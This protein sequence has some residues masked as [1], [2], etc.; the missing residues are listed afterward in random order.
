MFSIMRLDG[1]GMEKFKKIY[2]RAIRLKGGQ[3]AIDE[4]LPAPKTRQALSAVTD[5]R[6]LAEMARCVFRSGFVWRIVEN[7]WTNFEQVFKGFKPRVVERFSD[8]K[9]EEIAQDTAIIR[10]YKKIESVRKNASFVRR[11]SEDNA[12]FGT[13]LGDWPEDDVVG[14]LLLLKK[15]GGRLGGHTGQYFLRFSGKDTF[16]FS[17]DVIEVLVNNKVV[18]KE[19]TSKSA[20]LAAQGAFNQWRDETGLPYCHLSRIMAASIERVDRSGIIS[21]T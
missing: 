10:H 19:P 9:L 5:D 17:P 13:F 3:E 16:L 6:Y 18:D 7:K 21:N 12:G 8:E 20:L 4:L 14:L 15:E 2:D 11:F 1:D